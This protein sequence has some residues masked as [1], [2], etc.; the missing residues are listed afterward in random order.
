MIYYNTPIAKLIELAVTRGEG[1]L[2]ASGALLVYTGKYTGRSPND[3]FIVE[4]PDITQEIW[5]ENTKKLSENQFENL[6]NKMLNYLHD[7]DLFIFSGYAGAD[8]NYRL[9]VKIINEY[10]WQNV[11]VQQLLIRPEDTSWPVPTEP[12]LTILAAPGFTANPAAD[13]TNSE[14]FIIINMD[15]KLVLI[16]GT[17][18]AGEIKKCVFSVMN[19][20]LPK[21]NILSMHCS[22]NQSS[23]GQVTLFFGLSGTGKTSLSSDPACH[24]IGDDEHGWSENGIF[25]IEG[26]CYAKCI[27]LSQE[28]EPQIWDAIKFGAILENVIIDNNARIPNYSNQA[29]T[30][31]TR[32]AYP[33]SHIPNSIYPGVGTHPSTVIFLTADAFGVLPP[34]AK[35]TPAQAMYY[36]LLGYTSKLAGTEHGI[37]EPQATFSPC[38]GAPFLPLKPIVYANLLKE[39]ISTHK[40]QVFLVN[41]GWQGGPYGVGKRIDIQVTRQ[42][43]TAAIQGKLNTVDYVTDPIFN[44]HIPVTCPEVPAS[45]LL[46]EKSWSDKTAY[47]N[48]AL[49]LAAMFQANT[50]AVGINQEIITKVPSSISL[51]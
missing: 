49:N 26:G 27:N 20:L 30:E 9:P 32:A 40:V 3:K 36:Y 44:L 24:L 42:M 28:N 47:R 5:W 48:M 2:T 7:K 15:K 8:V 23:Q 45:L 43:V 33:I 31:N 22:A 39:K 34:I 1:M 10:A 4:T 14:A 29:V 38:F 12:Q 16:G 11:F 19:Y 18:Y 50:T 35:L 21:Q 51:L 25:N 37:T 13:G 46:P 6:H 17:H 41:T